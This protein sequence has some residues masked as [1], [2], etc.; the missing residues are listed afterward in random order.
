MSAAVCERS[1]AVVDRAKAVV[2]FMRLRSA[3]VMLLIRRMLKQKGM[4][5][6]EDHF[7][8]TIERCPGDMIL[9][10]STRRAV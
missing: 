3:I 5:L 10:R 6:C 7:D 2:G 4:E 9:A 1:K 8:A